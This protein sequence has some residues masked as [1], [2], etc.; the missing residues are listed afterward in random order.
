MHIHTPQA[1]KTEH[2]IRVLSYNIQVAIGTSRAHHYVTRSWRHVLPHSQLYAN[3]NR[4]A[5]VL[6]EFDIVALQEVDAGSLRSAFTNQ[7]EYLAHHA[8]FA[9]WHCQVNRNLARI[10]R[11]SNSLLS[12]YKPHRFVEQKLS[13]MIP[14]RGVLLA[15][16]GEG[17]HQLAV[18]VLHLALSQRARL[19]QLAEVSELV[20]SY[21]HAVLMGDFNCEPDSKEMQFLIRNTD[22]SIPEDE[23][24]TF[25]SWQ[26]R[27]RLDHILITNKLEVTTIEVLEH[28][29]SDHLPVAMEI[30]LPKKLQ[31][32]N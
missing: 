29:Y 27:K 17:R 21:P 11:H 19:A 20:N 9:H 2:T 4:I 15:E 32:T 5:H 24:H 16:Y 1:L 12:R 22:L 13:G 10:A 31:L 26:P 30:R 6:A 14:G 18:L 23:G 8:R 7:T 28:M 3:L 25:P